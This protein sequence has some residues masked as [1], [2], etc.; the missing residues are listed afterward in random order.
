MKLW[1]GVICSV[2]ALR[3]GDTSPTRI[4]EAATKAVAMIQKSQENWYTKASC[5]SCHQQVFPALAF[6]YAR[7]HGIAVDESA[8][9]ADAV[10]AFGFYSNFERAVEYTHFIDPRWTTVTACGPRTRRECI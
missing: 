5:F 10:A 1:F 9:H 7:E 6:R 2:A 8:A 4:Q 3:A